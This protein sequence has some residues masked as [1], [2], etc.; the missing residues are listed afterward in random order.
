MILRHKVALPS[1]SSCVLL[2]CRTDGSA[3]LDTAVYTYKLY[4]TDGGVKL[5][6]RKS[7]AIEKQYRQ[8]C[9]KLAV[10]YR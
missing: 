2:L 6:K 10:A 1:P 5:L 8:N 7:G 9:G 3:V 4:T